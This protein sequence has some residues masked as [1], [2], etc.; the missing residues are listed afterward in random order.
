MSHSNYC[1]RCNDALCADDHQ[2]RLTIPAEDP[3]PGETA[4]TF[5]LLCLDCARHILNE[6][7]QKKRR[8]QNFLDDFRREVK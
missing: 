5:Q 1:D 8:R 4:S 2:V 6:M 7:E 3:Q